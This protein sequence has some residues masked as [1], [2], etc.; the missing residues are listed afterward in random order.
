MVHQVIIAGCGAISLCF[1]WVSLSDLQQFD[2]RERI[3][4]GVLLSVEAEKSSHIEQVWILHDKKYSTVWMA[5]ETGVFDIAHNESAS[6]FQ[7]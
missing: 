4:K 3:V 5:K 7:N 6:I 2:V 1:W